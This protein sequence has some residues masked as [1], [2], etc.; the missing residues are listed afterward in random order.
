MLTWSFPSSARSDTHV[1][2]VCKPSLPYSRPAPHLLVDGRGNA[3]SSISYTYSK[4]R[5]KRMDINI[6]ILSIWPRTTARIYESA[7]DRSLPAC[8][9]LELRRIGR[10]VSRWRAMAALVPS[11]TH[12]GVEQLDPGSG[13]LLPP[14]LPPALGAAPRT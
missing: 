11:D 13:S 2:I 14:L 3:G 10:A 1:H 7:P 6:F 8:A 9:R 4:R 12:P 5:L